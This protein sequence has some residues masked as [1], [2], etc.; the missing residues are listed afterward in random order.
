MLK[1]LNV[2]IL[3]TFI[4]VLTISA[5]VLTLKNTT[6]KNYSIS[7]IECNDVST[8]MEYNKIHL[9]INFSTTNEVFSSSL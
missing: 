1:L 4:I 3:I 9:P 8:T 7:T 2:F 6:T 5:N